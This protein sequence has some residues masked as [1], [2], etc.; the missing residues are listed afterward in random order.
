VPISSAVTSD[1]R[2]STRYP[3]RKQ[4]TSCDMQPTACIMQTDKLHTQC[5]VAL[6]V[7]GSATCRTVAD[8][9]IAWEF[10][11]DNSKVKVIHNSTTALRP[12]APLAGRTDRFL[13]ASTHNPTHR[14][15]HARAHTPIHAHPICKRAHVHTCIHAGTHARTHARMYTHAHACTHTQVTAT[16]VGDGWI[17][18]GLGGPPKGGLEGGMVGGKPERP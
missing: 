18:V 17:G 3:T 1:A 8:V 15:V 14:R 7:A 12:D 6:T 5:A 2:N 9:D 16:A 11:A 4:Q 10:T 13:G